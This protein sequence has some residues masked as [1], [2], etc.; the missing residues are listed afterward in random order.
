MPTVEPVIY[1]DSGVDPDLV[2]QPTDPPQAL[3]PASVLGK[4]ACYNL[5]HV[6]LHGAHLSIHQLALY[7][8]R[9]NVH[10]LFRCILLE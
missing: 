7:I 8:F 1:I 6:L 4:W 2:T 9:S 3:T 5:L 10:I